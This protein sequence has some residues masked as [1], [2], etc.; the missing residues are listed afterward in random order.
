MVEWFKGKQ[1]ETGQKARAAA[2]AG[3][4]YPADPQKLSREIRHML[5]VANTKV[6]GG[7][8]AAVAPHAGYIYS[9]EVAAYAYSALKG[10]Q[11]KRVV[12]ISPSHCVSFRGSSVYDGDSYQTPLGEAPVDREFARR[13]AAASAA[14]KL[15]GDGH[16]VTRDGAEHAI[17][18][19]LPWLKTVL[20]D[21]ELVAVVM[22]DHDYEASRALGVALAELLKD[23]PKETL[24]L[25]SSD[26]SHYHS[27]A[28]AKRMDLKTLEAVHEWDY[29]SLSRN[30]R[31]GVWEACGGAAIVAAMIYAERMGA[32]RAEVLGYANSGDV[33]GDHTR[34]VGYGAA[35]FLK[36]EKAEKAEAEFSLSAEEKAELLALARKTVEQMV[37]TRDLYAPAPPESKALN[38]EAGAF[39]T[40]TSN[41]HL[42]GCVGYTSAAKPLYETVRDTAILAATR[43]TRFEPV[44]REELGE[45]HYEISVL[46]PLRRVLD[47]DEIVVGRDGL[48]VKNGGS[49]GLLLPQVAE[50]YGWERRQFVEQ[51]CVKAGL[52]H[53]AWKDEGTDIF[54]FHAIVFHEE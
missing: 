9:G 38:R 50:E 46:S 20:E 47:V 35:V 18:V 3:K 40:L 43:D 49:E 32:N 6:E 34:V 16:D 44:S 31:A 4:F 23:D 12:V 17:E 27:Y 29:L 5:A 15:S 19:Q 24:V 30:L 45:I 7:I 21:F 39:V 42:R 52:G 25:A 54:R 11:Y 22:G 2:V 13:L 28:D 26:L 53:D 33:T 8:L 48:L 41:G 1:A 14:I 10:R 36:S 37:S 51:T